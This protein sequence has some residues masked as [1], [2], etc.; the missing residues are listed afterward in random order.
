MRAGEGIA[1]LAISEERDIYIPAVSEDERF[2]NLNP[3]AKFKSLLVSPIR[4]GNKKLG[5]LSIQSEKAYA[6][7]KNEINILGELGQQAAIA[8]E[9]ARLYEAGQQELKERIQAEEELRASEERYRRISEDISAMICRYLEDGTL[10]FTNIVYAQFFGKTRQELQGT[11]LLALIPSDQRESVKNSYSSLTAENPYSTYETLEINAQGEKRWL[12][13]TDRRIEMPNHIEYQSVGIDITDRKN[14]DIERE[15]LLKITQEQ[16]LL[17]ETSAEA[18]LA[19]VS[20]TETKQVLN[21][22]LTQ[23][24]RLIPGCAVNISLF[25]NELLRPAAWRGYEGRGEEVFHSLV[26]ETLLLPFQKKMLEKPEVLIVEDTHN[27]PRWLHVKGLDWIRSNISI[28]LTWND[29]LL[30]LLYLD[31]ETPGKFTQETLQRLTPLINATVVALESALLIEKTSQALKET[32]A[33]YRINR[34]MVSVEAD[35][36]LNDV[37]EL[38][39]NNFD[40][41]HV[42]IFMLNPETGNFTLKAAS[43]ELGKKLVAAEHELQAGLG[44]IGYAAETRTPFFTNNVD[45]VVFFLFDP[46]LPDTKAEMSIPVM[47]GEKLYGILDIQQTGTKSF[48]ERDQQ[49]VLAIAGQLAMAL[50]KAELYQNLQLALEQEKAVRNQLVQNERLA[51]MGRLL[52][53][54]SHELNNPLQAIQN[55]LFL[56]KE[57]KGISDQGH[58]DLE[59]VL[60][61]SERMASLIDRLRT[62]YRPPQMEDL[63]NINLNIIVEDVLALL[64]THLR[65]NEISFEFHPDDNLPSIPVVSDQIRQVALNLLMNAVEA[66]PN[67]GKLTVHTQR[68]HENNELMLS[69]MD[70]GEGI[71]PEILPH[72]F[73][74]FVT[75]KKRG[76]GLGLTITHDIVLKHRGRITAENTPEFGACF[77]VWLPLT[78]LP[79]EIE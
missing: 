28:P 29:Q 38:L 46:Y 27:E 64:T 3:N 16:R 15:N 2:I 77:K 58:N 20:H 9:N 12:Q 36:L 66:M 23:V 10:L 44:I 34:G 18:T 4:S 6:F 39:K 25:E 24:Q 48:S 42:Q 21:E 8:I 68:L 75:N 31:G 79:A 78:S 49:L 7:S 63:Q 65:K 19:L 60:A 57:E 35:E 1:G 67:G 45:E 55:A 33:L 53:S 69:V 54:V 70:T 73:D 43:G 26:R 74:P 32:S 71:S 56:L 14:A 76:T 52:A 37:V 13:W 72:I 30:G 11:N 22:I 59:I 5:T 62:T 41:Y 40:Y 50:H 51:V 47:N 61:E 17:A